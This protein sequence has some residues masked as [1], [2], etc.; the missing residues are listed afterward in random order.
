MSP[1]EELQI[2]N[3]KV[4]FISQSWSGVD[5]AMDNILVQLGKSEYATIHSIDNDDPDILTSAEVTEALEELSLLATLEKQGRLRNKHAVKQAL[6]AELNPNT[7]SYV[8]LENYDPDDLFRVKTMALFFLKGL[9]YLLVTSASLT[10]IYE[11][12]GTC[13]V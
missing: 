4:K 8:N 2:A 10:V 11:A 7:K 9:F 6:A 1:E 12:W 5:V 13:N 3:D